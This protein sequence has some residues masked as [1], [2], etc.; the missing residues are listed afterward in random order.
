MKDHTLQNH[1]V[2][3]RMI[4]VMLLSLINENHK[5]LDGLER[6]FLVYGGVCR[7]SWIQFKVIKK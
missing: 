2:K 3:N 1:F 5:R 7:G 4:M 6:S